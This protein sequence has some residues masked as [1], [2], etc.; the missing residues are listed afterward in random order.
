MDNHSDNK[1]QLKTVNKRQKVAFTQKEDQLIIH[2]VNLFGTKKWTLIANFVK[3]RTSKQCRD[4]YMNYLKPGLSNIEWTQK[5]DDLLLEL[6]MKY[7][8]KWSTI[9]K[10]FNNR[11][12][13]SLKNRFIFLQKQIATNEKKIKNDSH[14]NIIKKNDIFNDNS[15]DLNDEQ[16]FELENFYDEFSSFISF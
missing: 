6:Y 10:N 5:E 12:Q 14:E 15:F 9:C 16:I 3:G 4:R 13:V 7:G 8:P 1:V 11:N 2:Y